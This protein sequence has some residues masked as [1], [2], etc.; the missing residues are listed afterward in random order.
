MDRG[1][2][3]SSY[4]GQQKQPNAMVPML[5]QANENEQMEED[6]MVGSDDEA[7][8]DKQAKE[9]LEATFPGVPLDELDD[10]DIALGRGLAK[11]VLR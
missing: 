5:H 3:H 11:D 6:E 8:L 9:E 4:S 7:V 10:D 2:S 1:A